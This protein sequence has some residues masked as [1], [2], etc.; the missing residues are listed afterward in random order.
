[1]MDVLRAM[2]TSVVTKDLQIEKDRVIQRAGMQ[3]T[4]FVT[5]I[6]AF[7]QGWTSAT[8]AALTD[9]DAR[10]CIMGHASESKRQLLDAAG[11][12]TT[13]SLRANV[14]D[15]VS[16]WEPRGRLL[17]ENLLKVVTK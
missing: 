15:V 11:V 6:D 3:G 17:I 9:P 14:Q 7:Y 10:I 8:A 1:M 4:N 13:G 12:S 5:A 2:I 16:T